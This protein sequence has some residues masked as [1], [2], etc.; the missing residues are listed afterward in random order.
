MLHG[1]S[2]ERQVDTGNAMKVYIIF[3]HLLLCLV[4]VKS[5]FI[6]RVQRKFLPSPSRPELSEHYHRMVRFHTRI[7]GNV[8][9]ASVIFIGD[10]MFQGLS[11]TAVA[12]PSVNYGIGGDT[13]F[14]ILQRLPNYHSVDNAKAVVLAV[15]HN[16]MRLRS[17]AE[18]FVNCKTISKKIHP[19]VPIFFC[20]VLPIDIMAQNNWSDVSQDRI[21]A[22]NAVLENWAKEKTNVTFVNISE[23]LTDTQG[24]LADKYHIGDGVHLNTSGNEILIRRLRGALGFAVK[25]RMA[26]KKSV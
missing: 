22:L 9:S 10:S 23:E 21:Q 8:P 5:D 7:D 12:N 11:V 2:Y 6:Q 18:I 24:N 20:A 19:D 17:N 13:T 3:L 15:G 14:G 26:E 4:L 16:D 1:T 25:K